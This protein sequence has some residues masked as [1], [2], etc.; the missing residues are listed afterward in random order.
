MDF[1]TNVQVVG[2][3]FL[4]RGYSNGKKVIY[5]EEFQPTVYLKSR[6]KT[7]WKTLDGENVEPIQPGTV[8]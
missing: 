1:Y 3:N 7:K 8:K 2:N 5:K 4:I 6:K